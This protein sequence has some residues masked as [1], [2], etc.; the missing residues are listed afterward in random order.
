MNRRNILAGLG[1]AAA[2]PFFL[3]SLSAQGP[4][5]GPGMSQGMGP[6]PMEMHYM[7]ETKHVGS[8]SLLISREALHRAQ[9]PKVLEFAKFEVAEQETIADI[10]MGMMMPPDQVSGVVVPPT[11][12]QAMANLSGEGRMNFMRLRAMN[13]PGFE[14]EFITAEINGH[15]KLLSIQQNYLDQGHSRGAINVAKLAKGMI[16]EHLQLLSDIQQR[17]G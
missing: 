4:G 1:A 15:Q 5:M 13:G 12:E 10:L 16:T 3:K 6:G 7:E 8:L 14:A 9:N 11:N 2:T 17:I